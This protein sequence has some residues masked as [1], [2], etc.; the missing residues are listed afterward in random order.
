MRHLLLSILVSCFVACSGGESGS[1]A[2]QTGNGGGGVPAGGGGGGGPGGGGGGGSASPVAF[3]ETAIDLGRPGAFPSDLIR[4]GSGTLFTVDDAAIPANVLGFDS[5]TLQQV[6]RIPITAAHLVDHDGK[7]PARAPTAFGNGLFGAFTGDLAIAF[8]RWLLVTVSAGN[9]IS[10]DGAQPL[11]LANLVVIDLQTQQVLQ[12]VNL[13]WELARPGTFSNG[14]DYDAIPQSLPSMVAFVP[15]LTGTPTGTIYVALSNG[16]GS[17]SGLSL[18]HQ[19]TV[20]SWRADFTKP[21]PLSADFVGKEPSD[22]TRTYVSDRYNP[23]GLTEH[24]SALGVRRL[25]LTSAGASEFDESF[26]VQPT[27]NAYLEVLDLPERRWREDWA[28]DLGPILP[29]TQ[30]VA[31]GRDALDRGFGVLTSQTFAAVY[32]VD[33]SGLDEDV[34]PSGLRLLRTASLAPGGAGTAG[35][36]FQPG[37]ALSHTHRSAVVT[38]FST[39]SLLVVELPDD[40]ALGPIVVNPPPFDTATLGPAMG[41]GLGAV[42]VEPDA[43][44][45]FVVNGSFD[46]NFVPNRNAYVASLSIAGGLP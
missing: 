26:V 17:S 39:A 4:D 13:A 42:V 40:V 31:I 38:S 29:A 2:P 43:P 12:T 45:F 9:S 7:T 33:L 14:G 27:T 19:G 18:F 21:E 36:G 3:D 28:I 24:G 44:I 8:E 15:N 30:R 32:V 10:D 35:S 5:T 1:P 23:V 46:A 34:D 16:A 6:L 20:Q 37:I 22:V 25:L 41:L 11:R